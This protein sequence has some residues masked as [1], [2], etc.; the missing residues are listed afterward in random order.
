MTNNDVSYNSNENDLKRSDLKAQQAINE[1]DL[2]RSDLKK[3]QA[4]KENDLKPKR[5]LLQKIIKLHIFFC[6]QVTTIL[7]ATLIAT[8]LHK[9]YDVLI[10]FSFGSFI[11][12]L[13]IAAYSL[14]LKFDVLAS[15]EF[16]E[17]YNNT[18]FNL[19][20]RYV[21]YDETSFFPAMASFAIAW[22]IV[23][24]LLALYYVKGF[25]T[26]SINTNY[27]Y[28]TSYIALVLLYIMNYNSGFKLYNN[29]LKMTNYEYNVAMAILFLISAGVIY[30]FETIK[31]NYLNTNCLLYLL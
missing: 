29:S 13:F 20:K 25:I 22:H 11:S 9:C 10:Y 7:V 2:K 28:I 3:E 15:R 27:S 23:F 17:K 1:N 21:P 14:L 31:S 12:V 6:V 19:W 18:I 26:N 5:T 16:N 24:A 8:R 4:I 30:Y